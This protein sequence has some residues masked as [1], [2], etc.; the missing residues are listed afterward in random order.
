MEQV[1]F[2]KMVES[3]EIMSVLGKQFGKIDSEKRL[4]KVSCEIC[5]I[6]KAGECPGKGYFGRR[7][8][9]CAAQRA[10]LDLA[11]KPAAPVGPR[12]PKDRNEKMALATT[13]SLFA[14]FKISRMDQVSGL[15]CAQCA[16]YR[17]KACKGRG[18]SD[19]EILGCMAGK[20]GK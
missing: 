3:V 5:A 8:I 9:E 16:D 12:Q 15:S 18:L 1:S 2:S 13:S 6:R 7:A 4:R 17:S 14:R 10:S 11:P 20:G 19:R